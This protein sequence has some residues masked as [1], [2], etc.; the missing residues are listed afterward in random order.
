MLVNVLSICSDDELM[1]EGED[2]FDGMTIYFTVFIVKW[3]CLT[4]QFH[5]MANKPERDSL[6]SK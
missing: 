1:T 5:Q 6:W 3:Y 4:A 2:Q